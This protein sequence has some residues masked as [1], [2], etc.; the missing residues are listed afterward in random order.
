MVVRMPANL[1]RF[2]NSPDDIDLRGGD[3]IVIPKRPDFV[4][5]TGQVYNQNAIT[6][7]PH[8]NAE[9]YLRQA[10]GATTMANRRA[11]FVIRA[12]GSI[13]SSTS[14]SWL[15]HGGVLKTEIEPGDTIVVPEKPV[16]GST[17]WRNLIGIAQIASSAAIAGVA[18]GS[19]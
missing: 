4:L 7:L 8:R 14:N 19:L 10:G 2:R 16:G 12:N 17:A 15:L 9:W 6:F 18:V 1:N 11:T 5:V 13:V 3:A